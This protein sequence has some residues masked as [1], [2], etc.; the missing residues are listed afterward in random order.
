VWVDDFPFGENVVTFLANYRTE[1]SLPV[2]LRPRLIIVHD[3]D[4]K[5]PHNWVALDSLSE[6]FSQIVAAPLAVDGNPDADQRH[7]HLKTLIRT[8]SQ[9][10]QRLRRKNIAQ[11]SALHLNKVFKLALQ[12]F[13]ENKEQPFD[14][15]RASRIPN[16]IPPDIGLHIDYFHHVCMDANLTD[17]DCAESIASALIMDHYRPEMPRR[18]VPS[19]PESIF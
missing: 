19:V 8:Q 11:I 15:I 3:T 7:D 4:T 2:A 10:V 9:E 1:A 14:L 16:D 5:L 13:S 12:H 18:F 6:T 17:M